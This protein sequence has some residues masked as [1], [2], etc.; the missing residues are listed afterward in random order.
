MRALVLDGA[1]KPTTDSTEL[2]S[3]QGMSFD[4]SFERFAAECDSD[5]DCVLHEVGPT[6]EVYT[7][8]VSDLAAAGSF[9]TS[10]PDRVLTPGELELAAIA[11]LYNTQLWPLFARGVYDATT[12][13]DGTLLQALVDTYVGRQPD[14]TYDNSQP[15]GFAINC[16]DDPSRPTEEIVRQNSVDAAALS[17]W[18]GDFLR[19]STGCI[20]GPLP[21]DT[22]LIGPAVGAAPIL[23]IGNTGDPATPYE[24]S[25]AMADLLSSAELFSVESN[26]HTAFL[27]VPCVEPVVVDYLVDLV[28]PA[29]GS[30]CINTAD[31]DAFPPAG[32]GDFDQLIALFDCLRDNGADIPEVT[33]GDLL[34]D[35][36]GEIL[37]DAID[38]T[39][40]AFGRAVLACEDLIPEL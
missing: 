5:T 7:A 2:N 16:A 34:A 25:V 37:L 27:S 29:Q 17:T 32:D 13:Q 1:V 4:R 30:S 38:P 6:I 19:A 26:G 20:G 12:A 33:I 24:W 39:D 23:V 15:A 31:E 9:P 28:M 35:P 22:L 11:S 14:G 8:L 21:V 3:E 10:E 36:S 18:F 40:P